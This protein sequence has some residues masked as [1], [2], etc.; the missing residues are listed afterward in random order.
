MIR[1]KRLRKKESKKKV[2]YNIRLLIYYYLIGPTETF[3]NINFVNSADVFNNKD[4][5]LDVYIIHEGK[6]I[7]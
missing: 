5:N 4:A 1:K 2:G 6:Y 3:S 7:R